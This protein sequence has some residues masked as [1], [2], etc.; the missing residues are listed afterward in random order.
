MQTSRAGPLKASDA[1]C[2]YRIGLHFHL[3]PLRAPLRERNIQG[4]PV[5]TMPRNALYPASSHEAR[6]PDPRPLKPL[7][8][9]LSC[10]LP[11][12]WN[13]APILGNDSLVI[14]MGSCVSILRHHPCL[15]VTWT[16]LQ[17]KC[18]VQGSQ[19]CGASTRVL[20]MSVVLNLASFVCSTRLCMNGLCLPDTTEPV[21]CRCC[22][23]L[24]PLPRQGPCQLDMPYKGPPLRGFA[25]RASHVYVYPAEPTLIGANRPPTRTAPSP[26]VLCSVNQLPPFFSHSFGCFTPCLNAPLTQRNQAHRPDDRPGCPCIDERTDC[27]PVLRAL[28]H[29][30][31]PGHVICL[32]LTAF[33]W[34]FHSVTFA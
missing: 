34:T 6:Y 2:V 14:L 18:H 11:S 32:S 33:T 23:Y 15:V 24:I 8:R 13:P 3:L 4:A 7:S 12:R 16:W 25:W 19:R 31:A 17:L 21:G 9:P 30:Y 5:S 1:K 10:Y 27:E 26:C 29:E 22:L 28:L 20:C